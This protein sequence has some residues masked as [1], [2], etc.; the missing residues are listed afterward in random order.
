MRSS[1]ILGPE[2]GAIWAR[3]QKRLV[4]N[5]VRAWKRTWMKEQATDEASWKHTGERKPNTKTSPNRVMGEASERRP[6]RKR[7]GGDAALRLDRWRRLAT[8]P[9]RA[10]FLGRHAGGW[11]GVALRVARAKDTKETLESCRRE[12]GSKRRNGMAVVGVGADAENR[13]GGW[14]RVG[15][16]A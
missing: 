6:K 12:R 11:E 7:A 9:M 2:R 1:V 13:A 8:D 4:Q 10:S 16:S 15:F 3:V 5:G 14:G